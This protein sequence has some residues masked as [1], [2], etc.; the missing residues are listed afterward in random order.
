MAKAKVEYWS[1][2]SPTY[3]TSVDAS[4]G[5]NTRP[6]VNK[7]LKKE[8]DL[9][10]VVEF[11]CGTGYF[12]RTLAER[13]ES[14]VA[15]DFSDDMLR[16][17][18]EHLKGCSN[19]RFQNVDC[20]HTP[21]ADAS[22]DT[23]FAGFVIPCVD[24]KVQALRESHR[25]LKPGGRL[26]V[27]NPNILLLPGIGK[28]KFLLRALIAWRGHLP[29]VSFCSVRDLVEGTGLVPAELNVVR[30]SAVAS[31]APVEYAVLVKPRSVRT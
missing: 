19:V 28:A 6:L 15:T 9:G 29:P 22:F 5:G 24:D 20:Q 10:V 11:G 12:T 18:E 14:V 16:M 4:L 27:A 8:K 26:I 17:A 3:D 7:L 30:D 21:F 23:I 13:A 31:S 1:R 2:S 25:I